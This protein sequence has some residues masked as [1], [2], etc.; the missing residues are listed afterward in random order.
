MALLALTLA[1]LATTVATQVIT[2]PL[3]MALNSFDDQYQG[4]GPD[5]M[6]E[7]PALNRSEFRKN[8][9]FAQVWPKAVAEWR[10]EGSRIDPLSSPAQAIAIMAYTLDVSIKRKRLYEE[11]NKKVREA[12]RSP[13]EY[14]DN[15]HFKILHFLL[16]DA[17]ATL[18]VAQGQKCR[19]V[20]RGVH[21]IKFKANVGDIVRFGQFASSSLCKRATRPFGTTTV[22]KVETC[23][24]A[25]IQA[26]SY[27]PNE[28]EVL[29]PPYEKFKV[30]YVNNTE[31]DKRKVEIHLD[32]IGTYS[33]YKCMWLRGGS[34]PTAPGHLGGLLLATTALAVATGIL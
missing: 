20:Y 29:I 18:S 16:T 22:F 1:L 27:F 17:L 26:F 5:M 8:P 15:F 2:V 10:K 30:T 34:D 28:E 32:S 33:Q 31:D 14:R 7:L 6:A 21:K 23:Q 11:F 9:L 13:Q 25:D 12:G 19:C 24:G 4:C 3:D